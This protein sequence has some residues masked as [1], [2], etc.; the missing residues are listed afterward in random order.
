[1]TKNDK[2]YSMK[3]TCEKTGLT[4]D[5]LKFYCNEGLIPNVKRNK[6]NYRVFND[7]DINW[8]KSLSC[9]KNC[10]MSIV[11]MKKYLDLCLKGEPTI[12]ERKVI[13]DAKLRELEHKKQEIQDSIDYIHWKHQFY[14]DVLSGKT[15]Y[16][17]YLIKTENDDN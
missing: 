16:F 15:K 10:G 2:L 5:A 13:L 9:L 3:E 7:N 1:M 17:S 14:D 12:P 6:S 11:E 8:I 4:Y